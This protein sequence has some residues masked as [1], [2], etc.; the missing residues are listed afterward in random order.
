MAHPDLMSLPRNQGGMGAGACAPPKTGWSQSG[1]LICQ[2]TPAG[3]SVSLQALF[4]EPETYTVQFDVSNAI[5][6]PGQPA[7]STAADILWSVKGNT[8]RRRVSVV[9]GMSISGTAEAVQVRAYDTTFVGGEGGVAGEPYTVTINLSK[10][11]RAGQSQQPYYTP[12]NLL[13]GAGSD[14]GQGVW[15][16]APGGT[17][18]IPIPAQIGATSV[19]VVVGSQDGSAI[20]DNAAQVIQDFVGIAY[21]PRIE[22][23]V[24]ISQGVTQISLKNNS[25]AQNY[26]FGVVLGIDG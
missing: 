21:D 3:P 8:V 7:Q 12:Q 18:A 24:P 19:H 22:L 5:T 26:I 23:W 1:K 17:A 9:S 6:A 13:P 10:G 4:P 2:N 25:V 11:L 14:T 16:L 15:R 20:P